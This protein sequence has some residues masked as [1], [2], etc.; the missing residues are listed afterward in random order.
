MLALETE[1]KLLKIAHIGLKVD[2]D[3]LHFLLQAAAHVINLK[4]FRL[5][6]FHDLL[7]S[8][9]HLVHEGANAAVIALLFDL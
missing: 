2:C 4:L 5:A 1:R 3:R 7:F 8:L 6:Q 9:L